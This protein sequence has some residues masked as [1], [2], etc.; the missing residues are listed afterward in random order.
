M[1]GITVRRLEPEDRAQVVAIIVEGLT[2]R[3]GTYSATMNPDLERFPESFNDSV[4][5]VASNA[6]GPVGVGILRPSSESESEIVRMSVRRPLRGRGIAG[7]ILYE[8]LA[9]ARRCGIKA[10]R[11]ET[12]ATWSS[13]IAFYEKHGFRRTHVQGGDQHFRLQ[14]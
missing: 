4:I 1:Q 13:A 2:D 11:V 5:L 8:L 14:L 7:A 6:T 12:T 9:T 10:V 3:W